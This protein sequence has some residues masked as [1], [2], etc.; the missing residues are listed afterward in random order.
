MDEPIILHKSRNEL[1]QDKIRYVPYQPFL[2]ISVLHSF[3]QVVHILDGYHGRT[4]PACL[5]YS[6]S[7]YTPR[8]ASL[9][10]FPHNSHKVE[11]REELLPTQV[12]LVMELMMAL[13]IAGSAPMRKGSIRLDRWE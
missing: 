6:D 12:A 11:G 10:I 1:N 4:H 8:L 3:I 2:F 5:A 13:Y 7:M 9:Y